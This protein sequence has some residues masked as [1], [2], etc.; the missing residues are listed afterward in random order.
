MKKKLL[1]IESPLQFINCF[2]YVLKNEIERKDFFLTIFMNSHR[3]IGNFEQIKNLMSLYGMRADLICQS[4]SIS[5]MR[6]IVLILKVL[7]HLLRFWR[8]N[9]VIVGD[10]RNS[11]FQLICLFVNPRKIIVV[12]D[13][14]SSIL[15]AEKKKGI[16]WLF[17]RKFERGG[18][19]HYF[20]VYHS[21]GIFEDYS[22]NSYEYTKRK[23]LE[24]GRP[25]SGIVFVGSSVVEVGLVDEST[26]MKSVER[27]M[28]NCDHVE[29]IPHRYE[30]GKKISVISKINNVTVSNYEL[31]LEI[32]LL[33]GK[34]APELILGT[35][36]S[37]FDN[38]FFL[39]LNIPVRIVKMERQG[40]IRDHQERFL[41][42]YVT[43]E[44]YG[45]ELMECK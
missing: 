28:L 31:P 18:L 9:T 3:S 13:G 38:L 19:I 44:R 39:K 40:I 29:Y 22:E 10:K 2:E 37:F 43:Y 26:Y 35:F 5:G 15:T 20:T 11:F 25:P 14:N 16:N 23:F 12:D 32:L 8:I 36:S 6:N 27:A 41:D 30:S 4:Y 24:K 45:Y 17:F 34:L 33:T 1:L 42:S 21:H 7:T